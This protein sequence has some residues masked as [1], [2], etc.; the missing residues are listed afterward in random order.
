MF[1]RSDRRPVSR[2]IRD[3][4]PKII[5]AELRNHQTKLKRN[6]SVRSSSIN[7]QLSKQNGGRL[8]RKKKDLN[9]S[10]NHSIRRPMDSIDRMIRSEVRRSIRQ[11]MI[12]TDQIST[13]DSASTM[14]SSSDGSE[15]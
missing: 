7:E 12:N 8:Y 6:T 2:S 10:F 3:I 5:S 14:S 1:C 11:S 15:K 9:Q 13:E 4:Q